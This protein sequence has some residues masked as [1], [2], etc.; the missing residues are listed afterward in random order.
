MVFCLSND[1]KTSLEL[2]LKD[3]FSND[4]ISRGFIIFEN[5]INIADD[6]SNFNQEY[7]KVLNNVDIFNV[8]E[9]SHILRVEGL[10]R[11]I[12][13][14]KQI[15][16]VDKNGRQYTLS[17]FY[18]EIGF[19]DW[20]NNKEVITARK[21]DEANKNNAYNKKDKEGFKLN[22][23]NDSCYLNCPY[24]I[25]SYINVYQ[26][27][28]KLAHSSSL[29]I[30]LQ[31]E[32]EIVTD[33]F[34]VC[35]DQCLKNEDLINDYF[36]NELLNYKI[37]YTKFVENPFNKIKEFNDKFLPLL[38]FNERNE[39]FSNEISYAVKFVGE[40]G[41]GK[42]TRM[43]KMYFDLVDEVKN[44][45]KNILP[46]WINLSELN[47]QNIIDLEELIVRELGEF[48]P[49]L[50]LLLKK[51]RVAL[52]L[53]G[54]NEIFLNT[55]DNTIKIRL[56]NDIDNLRENYPSVRIAITDRDKKSIP[57]CMSQRDVQVFSFDRLTL[58]EM[59]DYVKMKTNPDDTKK[60]LEYFDS[61]QAKWLENVKIIPSKLNSLI[62]L[63]NDD[64]KPEEEVDFYDKYLDFILEREAQEKKETRLNIL[65]YLLYILA[66]DMK[67]P[68]DEK[69]LNEIYNIWIEKCQL[70][71]DFKEIDEL[72]RL[73]TELSILVPGNINGKYRFA[74]E[75]YYYKL[76][77]E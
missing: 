11:K 66:N 7:G 15:S 36:E 58:N 26:I 73:A 10:F 30:N 71:L 12:D 49:H 35:I 25:K 2:L 19:Y 29:E 33:Y 21:Q 16:L 64:I 37:D 13:F 28:N 20:L 42:T 54:Y 51:G 63:L 48:A 38:W 59:Q 6:V 22:E 43:R 45:K 61:E 27:R 69:S 52:F 4:E 46:I 68:D 70:K 53:D 9:I 77:M 65:K 8:S 1:L 3:N 40:P 34:I 55:N 62:E 56:A 50:K 17:H 31:K 23:A 74:N 57:K 14:L 44:K 47:N 32:I 18:N 24:H 39:V 72:F 41:M 76:G 5:L 60:I 75:T 67:G